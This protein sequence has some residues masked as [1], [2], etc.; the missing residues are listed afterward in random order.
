MTR[1]ELSDAGGGVL[2]DTLK[3]VD[4][5]RVRI[6]LKPL[7]PDAE[8]G[9]VEIQNPPTIREPL[10]TLISQTV[11]CGGSASASGGKRSGTWSFATPIR[12]SAMP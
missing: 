8:T 2:A 11:A 4:E 1:G 5:V 7:R 10:S 3:H 12:L 9:A 6:C